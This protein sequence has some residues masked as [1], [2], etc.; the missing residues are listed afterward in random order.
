MSHI[1]IQEKFNGSPVDWMEQVSETDYRGSEP[2]RA[3]I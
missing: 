3:S 2:M 1:A